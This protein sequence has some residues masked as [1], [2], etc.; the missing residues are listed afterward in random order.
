[1]RKET[2]NYKDEESFCPFV[3]RLLLWHW[4]S[5]G[6]INRKTRTTVRMIITKAQLMSERCFVINFL[7]AD[8]F[9]IDT[10]R[11]NSLHLWTFERQR[12]TNVIP[13]YTIYV[14]SLK[15]SIVVLIIC[16]VICFTLIR[17]AYP[18]RNPCS[19]RVSWCRPCFCPL[20]FWLH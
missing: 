5:V 6:N 14:H 2:A 18:P 16:C 3:S 1:M 19:K 17:K 9:L 4:L 20:L 11:D 13:C 15:R 10:S 8:V 7:R 12:E